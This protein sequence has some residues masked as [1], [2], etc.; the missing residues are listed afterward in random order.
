MKTCFKKEKATFLP[1]QVNVCPAP[2]KAARKSV[3]F[4]RSRQTLSWLTSAKSSPRGFYSWTAET[5]ASEKS[6]CQQ[7]TNP[8]FLK[9]DASTQ[10]TGERASLIRQ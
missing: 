5:V 6:D 4:S 9:P 10:F 1:K 8:S 7:T 2:A 3:I